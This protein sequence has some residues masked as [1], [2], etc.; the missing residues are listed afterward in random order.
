M[1][2]V[3][4][5]RLVVVVVAKVGPIVMTPVEA[6]IMRV[7]VVGVLV[8][9]IVAVVVIVAVVEISPVILA[10]VVVNGDQWHLSGQPVVVVKGVVTVVTTVI[11]VTIV[12]SQ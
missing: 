7:G 3:R 2:G 5:R 1:T 6:L 8:L 11:L 4:S 10:G 9:F 12:N